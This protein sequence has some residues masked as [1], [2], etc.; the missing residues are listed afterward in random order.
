M[1][2]IRVGLGFK[3][4]E[5][6]ACLLSH[7]HQDHSKSVKH[8]TKAGIDTYMSEG[9]RNAIKIGNHRIKVIKAHKQFRIGTFKIVPF[10]TKHDAAEPLGFLIYSTATGEKLLFATDTYYIEYH[11]HKL[12]H[13]MVECNYSSEILK[14]AVDADLTPLALK[15]RL[16]SSHFSLENVLKFLKANDLS[17]VQA[18]IL[19]HLSDNNSDEALF[20]MEVQKATG[21]Q[22]YIANPGLEV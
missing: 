5:I 4:S 14:T 11:F 17:S 2:D 3:L 10:G 13:I 18:I 1:K 7:E 21:K 12:T 20:K 6:D 9:T 16:L 22:V 8:I 15:N 19:L